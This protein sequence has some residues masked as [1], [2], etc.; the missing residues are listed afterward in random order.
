MLEELTASELEGIRTV[1]EILKRAEDNK[2]SNAVHEDFRKHGV[3]L[4]KHMLPTV[5]FANYLLQHVKE[6]MNNSGIKVMRNLEKYRGVV[7]GTGN[8][9]EVANC[10]ADELARNF[11]YR[12]NFSSLYD[13]VV[14]QYKAEYE[15]QKIQETQAAAEKLKAAATMETIRVTGVR[16]Q[17]VYD[18]TVLHNPQKPTLQSPWSELKLVEIT[19][20]YAGEL[21]DRLDEIR[22]N[23][24]RMWDYARRLSIAETWVESNV[25]KQLNLSSMPALFLALLA[26]ELYNR[27]KDIGLF[28][29]KLLLPNLMDNPIDF[30]TAGCKKIAND[31]DQITKLLNCISEVLC[32]VVNNQNQRKVSVA[33]KEGMENLEKVYK[34]AYMEHRKKIEACAQQRMQQKIRLVQAEAKKEITRVEL[35]KEQAIRAK[36]RAEAEREKAM[37]R[38]DLLTKQLAQE[39]QD[40]RQLTT[41]VKE[42]QSL[43]TKKI[44][45]ED[46]MTHENRREQL[47]EEYAP[48]IKEQGTTGDAITAILDVFCCSISLIIPKVP[49]C[50]PGDSGVYDLDSLQR[51]YTENEQ[52]DPV[53][54]EFFSIN[55]STRVPFRLYEIEPT[56]FTFCS[57][58]SSNLDI[59]ETALLKM[60]AK[61]EAKQ[62]MATENSA[63]VETTPALG[64]AF[65]TPS[66]SKASESTSQNNQH[67]AMEFEA[68]SL[69]K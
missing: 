64:T 7:N 50:L 36:I 55:P 35:E 15:R 14:E 53:T 8:I 10:I 67:T 39:T 37:Q 17:A 29:D 18:A 43:C 48:E 6:K 61:A 31:R 25:L 56:G 24:D 2:D 38:A 41:K 59:Y 34:K 44:M 68:T 60:R 42:W 22:S 62:Q 49:V 9:H 27:Q 63:D 23:L 11:D 69:A 1:L 13:E 26:E 52:Q 40:P 21:R 4:C 3:A 19:A 32:T 20:D 66:H 28:P 33:E 54:R 12:K 45:S 30:I 5:G 16:V 58:I 65:F 51:W 47:M 46:R 57:L